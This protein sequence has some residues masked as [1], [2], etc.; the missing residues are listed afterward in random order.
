M[1]RGC[2][3][4]GE[5]GGLGFGLVR[6]GLLGLDLSDDEAGIDRNGA[7][8]RNDD[9]VQV[10]FGDVFRQRGQQAGGAGE[11]GDQGD[12]CVDVCLDAA[13]GA[14]EHLHAA[15]FGEH[16]A[17]LVF[18][19]GRQAEG[20]VFEDLDQDAAQADHDGPA[21]SGGAHCADNDFVAGGN[22]FLDQQAVEL[23]PE[24]GKAFA[25]LRSDLVEFGAGH[26]DADTAR[27]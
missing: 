25:H 9:R 5:V 1:R 22:H 11:A 14:V 4:R 7:G 8:V 3:Q 24:I 21:Q 26:A 20:H 18:G 10:D 2:E 6:G 17:D 13:A 23:V 16:V 12:Q 19:Q 15:Q 27:I